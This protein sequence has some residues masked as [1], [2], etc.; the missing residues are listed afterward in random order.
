MCSGSWV[1]VLVTAILHA[2]D[3]IH[4]CILF[5]PLCDDL[6]FAKFYL[7]SRISVY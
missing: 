6:Q 2:H 5:M 1:V 7:T 3:Q 4:C